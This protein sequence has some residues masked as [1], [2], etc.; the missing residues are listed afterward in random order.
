MG[1]REL[2]ADALDAISSVAGEGIRPRADL[3]V[4]PQ[5]P[6]SSGEGRPS[7]TLYSSEKL[8]S[9]NEMEQSDNCELSP[10]KTINKT[11]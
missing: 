8:L 9:R 7:P 3:H 5:T 10:P 1:W 2:G 4:G 6:S 11:Y